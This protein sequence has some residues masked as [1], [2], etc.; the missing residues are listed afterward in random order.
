MPNLDPPNLENT[1]FSKG[2]TMI[3][4]KIAYRNW[5][6]F[7]IDLGALYVVYVVNFVNSINRSAAAL[8]NGV[9][10]GAQGKLL[11]SIHPSIHLPTSNS[12]IFKAFGNLT[13]YIP[14]PKSSPWTSAL[15]PPRLLASSLAP[16]GRILGD[17]IA[18]QEKYKNIKNPLGFSL[19][20]SPRRA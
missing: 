17:K 15:V 19:F 14:P 6:R 7:L 10:D 11:A 2:K 9:L 12:P 20:L 4:Q 1:C 13:A 16:L 18:F 5:H 3:I 8:R